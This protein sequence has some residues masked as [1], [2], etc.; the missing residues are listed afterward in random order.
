MDG[1]DAAIDIGAAWAGWEEARLGERVPELTE[2]AQQMLQRIEDAR[3]RR[4]A[5]AAETKRF[6]TDANTVPEALLVKFSA[7]VQS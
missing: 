7:L 2:Q 4:K 6:R 3:A 1:A 5:L